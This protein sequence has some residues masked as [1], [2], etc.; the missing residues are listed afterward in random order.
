MTLKNGLANFDPHMCVCADT[1]T[2]NGVSGCMHKGVNPLTPRT[3]YQV[4]GVT[5]LTHLAPT[6]GDGW[7][8]IIQ[9]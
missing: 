4:M 6:A 7:I 3:K 2:V 9:G 1:A 5:E 8:V